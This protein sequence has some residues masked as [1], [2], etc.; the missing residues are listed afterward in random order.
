MESLSG[1]TQGYTHAAA[2]YILGQ[3]IPGRGIRG[4]ARANIFHPRDEVGER[5]KSGKNI[6]DTG[7]RKSLFLKR[8]RAIAATIDGGSIRLPL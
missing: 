7:T 5:G 2:A 1:R 6:H 4:I 3:V 8:G